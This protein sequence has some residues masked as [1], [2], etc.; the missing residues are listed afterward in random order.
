MIFLSDMLN[1]KYMISNYLKDF[2][3][4]KMSY[5]TTYKQYGKLN[6]TDTHPFV[7]L[8]SDTNGNL[9]GVLP[10]ISMSLINDA[11]ANRLLNRGKDIVEITQELVDELKAQKYSIN[12]QSTYQQIETLLQSQKLY[13]VQ[14]N[15]LYHQ[16]LIFE[17][18]VDNQIV[19]NVLYDALKDFFDYYGHIFAANGMMNI[20]ISGKMDGD[21][22]FDFGRALYG[23]SIN[24]IYD[25]ANITYQIDETVKEIT[26]IDHT[27]TDINP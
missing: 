27:I 20:D 7:R 18:W 6:I 12:P 10:S 14:V 26:G 22:N 2:F 8:I 16:T 24:M 25:I 21:Y 15:R 5:N 19:K 17:I 11:S 13:A 23:A 3:Y 1:V 9:R 4:S